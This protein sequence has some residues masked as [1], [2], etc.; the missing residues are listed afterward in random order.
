MMVKTALQQ[1]DQSLLKRDFANETAHFYVFDMA[2]NYQNDRPISDFQ[3]V[4]CVTDHDRPIL[5]Q[6]LLLIIMTH[7]KFQI[8]GPSICSYHIFSIHLFS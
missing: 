6:A 5:T 1:T 8:T 4:L 7:P 2:V 3:S